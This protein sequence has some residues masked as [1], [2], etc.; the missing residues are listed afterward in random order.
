[1]GTESPRTDR[2]LAAEGPSCSSFATALRASSG[3]SAPGFAEM[4]CGRDEPSATSDESHTARQ[5]S[6]HLTWS[7]ART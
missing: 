3:D 6:H 7:P 1:M 5:N 4:T 2:S